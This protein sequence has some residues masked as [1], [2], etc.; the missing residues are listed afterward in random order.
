MAVAAVATLR[1]PAMAALPAAR[2]RAPH[3]LPPPSRGA[4]A[5]AAAA[6][7]AGMAPAQAAAWWRSPLPP[8]PRGLHHTLLRRQARLRPPLSPPQRRSRGSRLHRL[9]EVGSLLAPLSSCCTGWRAACSAGRTICCWS[10]PMPL[11]AHTLPCR[12]RHPGLPQ[13]D[14]R[15]VGTPEHIRVG[16]Q[17]LCQPVGCQP[18]SSG[19]PLPSGAACRHC[20]PS[21]G[22]LRRQRGWVPLSQC[23]VS[24]CHLFPCVGAE[25]AAA[26]CG[27]AGGQLLACPPAAPCEC[28]FQTAGGEQVSG[29]MQY[30]SDADLV[31]CKDDGSGTGMAVCTPP[32]GG[33]AKPQPPGTCRLCSACPSAASMASLPQPHLCC[34]S[35]RCSRR[36]RWPGDGIQ[37]CARAFPCC[38]NRACTAAA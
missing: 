19:G 11:P 10:A 17:G 35:C 16:L 2:A 1:P 21:E 12:L 37:R 33:S 26:P 28:R 34:G 27:S 5:T 18:W 36:T 14:G 22:Q 23:Q 32:A 7:P 38:L 30:Q 6:L 31:C 20:G 9:A 13:H 4:A 15:P 29:Y 24:S 3:P 8:R 25:R